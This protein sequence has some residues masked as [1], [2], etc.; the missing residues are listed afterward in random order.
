MSLKDAGPKVE[1]FFG[2]SA[3]DRDLPSVNQAFWAALIGHIEQDFACS[4]G[5]ILD[6]GC[7][8][9]GLLLEL[10]RRFS[11]EALYGIEPLASARAEAAVRLR[12]VEAKVTL[13]E[14][15][16]WARIPV[17]SVNLATSHETLYLEPDIRDF[18]KRVRGILAPG[19]AAYAVLGC[20]SENPVWQLWKPQ[21]LSAGRRV[22]DYRPFEVME[23]AASAGLT[24]A[25]QPLRRSGWI[26]YD[27]TR[28]AF[29]YPDARTMF[30]HHYRFKL[31]FRF[32]VSDERTVS[33]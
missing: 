33:S 12:A 31:V 18:M 20:H 15:S 17:G 8:S 7:H 19:G 1:T 28:A 14:I 9:G 10:H 27:P 2:S 13:L 3:L 4:P 32:R 23:A 26:T 25:V 22:Y 6:I 5:T 29:R 24:P 11:P 16:D 30:E 21:L